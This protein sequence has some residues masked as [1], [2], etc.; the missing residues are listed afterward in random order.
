MNTTDESERKTGLVRLESTL[1]SHDISLKQPTNGFIISTIGA[2]GLG[3]LMSLIRRG[4]GRVILAIRLL[5]LVLS[6]LSLLFALQNSLTGVALSGDPLFPFT[7]VSGS[8]LG[9]LNVSLTAYLLVPIALILGTLVLLSVDLPIYWLFRNDDVGLKAWVVFSTSLWFII[10]V[11]LGILVESSIT[12]L[13][14]IFPDVI[15]QVYVGLLGG[16]FCIWVIELMIFFAVG[17]EFIRIFQSQFIKIEG[18]MIAVRDFLTK[19]NYMKWPF[20]GVLGATGTALN[21]SI[22]VRESWINWFRVIIFVSFS[23]CI[24]YA[25]SEFG[26]APLIPFTESILLTLIGVVVFILVFFVINNGLRK[27][28]HTYWSAFL[29]VTSVIFIEGMVLSL[30]C[31]FIFALISKII[32]LLFMV[33]LSLSVSTQINENPD[34]LNPIYFRYLLSTMSS[35]DIRAFV[36]DTLDQLDKALPQQAQVISA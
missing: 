30:V 26:P 32:G 13:L 20:S 23:V 14:V 36:G 28:V 31:G 6:S 17:R 19:R 16:A 33:I 10:T 3:T 7:E 4:K 15:S 8:P 34:I 1:T 11:P 27:S 25:L 35:E 29:V 12:W 18:R 21:R 9:I 2:P 24:D 22:F 5:T